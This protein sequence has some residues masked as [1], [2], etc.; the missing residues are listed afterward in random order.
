[1]IRDTL[2]VIDDSELDLAILN[3]IFKN[4][5]EVECARDA[6]RGISFLRRN[7]QRVCGILLDICLERR[8]EGFT[9][10]HQIQGNPD[11][12]AVP[13]ILITTDA[14]E[15]DV[16][17]SV[18]R[19]AV[20]FLVK[21]VDPRTVQERV[22]GVI[23]AAWP[24]QTTILD[25]KPEEEPVQEEANPLPSRIE[26]IQAARQ[27]HQVWRQK[28]E[29]MCR[30]RPVL[31]TAAY[32]QLGSITELLARS[33][34]EQHPDGP[35]TQEQAEMVG[36]AAEF[37]DVGLL[38]IPDRVV[39]AG[40]EQTGPEAQLYDQHTDLGRALFEAEG[41][42]SFL[43]RCAGEIA[44]WHHKNADG[45]GYPLEGDGDTIPLS[46]KLTRG[47]QQIQY[48]L[49]YYQG[50]SDIWE[51]LLRGLRSETGISLAP[52]VYQV[53]EAGGEKLRNALCFGVDI[54][55]KA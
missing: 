47:A 13:V 12:A 28:L 10:L 40:E 55:N 23:R 49:R 30:L 53:V 44:Q 20:D 24:A 25:R 46:A 37:C 29:T 27:L 11:T 6:R 41:D 14:N 43:F 38:G 45:S 4:L 17:A 19:G 26:T 33:Y 31:D 22:C 48:Y 42:S 32:Q 2:L 35:W 16:R 3:E 9:V 36:M 7:H 1:M 8:G 21:P 52:E 50:C 5:F 18:E 39:E 51:R 54:M 34:V 15:K